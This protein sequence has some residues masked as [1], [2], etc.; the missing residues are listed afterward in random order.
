MAEYSDQPELKGVGGWLLTFIIILS[1]ISPIRILL[2]TAKMLALDAQT[3][4]QLGSSWQTYSL[5]SWAL[6]AATIAWAWFLAYR[7]A[8]VHT[9]ASVRLVV[10][11]LWVL[12]FGP[13]LLDL[14]VA[15]LL[16]PDLIAAGLDGTYFIGFFQAAVFA[17]IWSLYL[18]KSKRVENTFVDDESEARKIFG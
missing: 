17:T 8:R 6:A 18:T 4:A 1:V 5:F 14:I 16:W 10:R 13:I 7:L 15:W 12:A 11:G 9:P 3:E 2:E